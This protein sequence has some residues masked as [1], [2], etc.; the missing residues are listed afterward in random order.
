MLIETMNEFGTTDAPSTIDLDVAAPARTG[1]YYMYRPV[2]MIKVNS[3]VQTIASRVFTFESIDEMNMVIDN[4]IGV[5]DAVVLYEVIDEGDG[6]VAR[7][8]VV[9]NPSTEFLMVVEPVVE[10]VEKESTNV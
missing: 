1:L 5:G 8:A 7:F 4:V 9:E 3:E 10:P 6:V 2:A